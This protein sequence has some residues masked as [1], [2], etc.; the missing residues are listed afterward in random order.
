[1]ADGKL[2][3][4]PLARGPVAGI[5]RE[6]CSR[7]IPELVEADLL[8]EELAQVK[9]LIA[10][11]AVRG[12]APISHVDGAPLACADATMRDHWLGKLTPLLSPIPTETPA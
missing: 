4:P 6:L 12:A 3:T 2:A 5:A 7:S 9:L 11:N 10:I 1:L 8:R